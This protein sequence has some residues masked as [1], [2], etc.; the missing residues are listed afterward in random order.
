MNGMS[1]EII[2]ASKAAVLLSALMAITEGPR[3]AYGVLCLAIHIMNFEISE[4]AVS[5][6]QLAAEVSQSL[7]SIERHNAQ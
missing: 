7:R 1:T 6:D 5:V 3:E 2:D 4:N